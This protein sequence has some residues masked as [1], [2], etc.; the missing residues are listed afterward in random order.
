M[1]YK[2][3]D[4]DFVEA[5]MR[6]VLP[7]PEKVDVDIPKA[8]TDTGAD[9]K[10]DLYEYAPYRPGGGRRPQLNEKYEMPPLWNLRPNRY[11]NIEVL[12][13]KIA[14]LPVEEKDKRVFWSRGRRGADRCYHIPQI[15]NDNTKPLGCFYL[16]PDKEDNI[17]IDGAIVGSAASDAFEYRSR[18]ITVDGDY[19]DI[20]GASPEGMKFE[21]KIMHSPSHPTI[22]YDLQGTLWTDKHYDGSWTGGYSRYPEPNVWDD[23]NKQNWERPLNFNMY[24]TGAAV[25]GIAYLS[26]KQLGFFGALDVAINFIAGVEWAYDLADKPAF[27]ETLEQADQEVASVLV[28]DA[29]VD[30]VVDAVSKIKDRNNPKEFTRS[31][32]PYVRLVSREA[33]RE[34]SGKERDKAWQKLEGK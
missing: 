20:S 13:A 14:E 4:K 33:G 9:W 5:R 10:E 34:V 17:I 26:L 7:E 28:A 24:L 1:D 12:L 11:E 31:G 2:I 6:I 25:Y 15:R 19:I 3:P 32:K 16:K 30:P 27:I 21:W 29:V 18:T 8:L 23:G 22:K